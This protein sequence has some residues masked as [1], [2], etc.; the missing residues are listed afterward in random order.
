MP[1][2]KNCGKYFKTHQEIDGKLRN[3]G[4]RKYCLECSPFNSH[5]TTNI[6]NKYIC[7]YCGKTGK[8]NFY[9]HH[10]TIC[11]SCRA[12]YTKDQSILKA[13]YAREKLGG[14]CAICGFDKYQCA[15]DIHHLDQSKKDKDFASHVH[16]SFE[17]IDSELENCILLCKNCHSAV[18]H[19][20]ISL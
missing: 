9:P 2:C 10:T 17:R 1:I 7:S 6:S 15:L 3:L 19:G 11:K 12:K 18:H 20:D 13:K 14:K 16:W 4:K 5:N 8:E